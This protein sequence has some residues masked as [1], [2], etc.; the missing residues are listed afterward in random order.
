MSKDCENSRTKAT[1]DIN[2]MATREYITRNKAKGP[3]THTS[4]PQTQKR[5]KKDTTTQE[6]QQQQQNQIATSHVTQT[7]DVI[8]SKDT[9]SE[10]QS[11]VATSS[12]AHTTQPQIIVA[13]PIPALPN[14]D[15]FD[16]PEGWQ[17]DNDETLDD[18]HWAE[19]SYNTRHAL[20]IPAGSIEGEGLR[21][22]RSTIEKTIPTG[23]R[24]VGTSIK[25]V[26]D[27][28]YVKIDF[29]TNVHMEKMASLLNDKG[30]KF[31]VNGY[32]KGLSQQTD[33]KKE[34]VVRD[35]PLDINQAEI[36]KHFSAYGEIE[37]IRV[38]A[39]S[40][41]HTANITFKSDDAIT[42]IHAQWSDVIRKDSVRIYLA[43]DFEKNK[44]TRTEFCAKLCNLPKNTTGFDIADFIEQQGGKTC[45]I[46][47][48][49]ETYNRL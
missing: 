1:S 26:D 20:L 21:D 37:R 35:I 6:Q 44:A 2:N 4:L 19:I 17:Y 36:E 42:Q 33:R 29:P 43:D 12:T 10:K 5:Q 30:I 9:F 23:I 18:L 38:K 7:R 27:N 47:R 24:Y 25:R 40:Q 16:T 41:W 3:Y 49:P 39:V 11:P 46:P 14:N 22:K 48:H 31:E 32:K 34:I 13:Q 8:I 15:K 45:F 28:V